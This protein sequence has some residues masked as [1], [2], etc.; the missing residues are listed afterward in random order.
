MH[1]LHFHE[2][3]ERIPLIGNEYPNM[4]KHLSPNTSAHTTLSTPRTRCKGKGKQSFM[5]TNT[6]A[7]IPKRWHKTAALTLIQLS[8][9]N[10]VIA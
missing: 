5:N 8:Y 3:D 10:L 7:L 2:E 9:V 1:L 6:Q 4:Q